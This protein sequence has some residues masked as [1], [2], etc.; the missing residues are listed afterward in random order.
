[1][2]AVVSFFV[3]ISL[4]AGFLEGKVLGNSNV[5]EK[6]AVEMCANIATEALN[7]IRT[8]ASLGIERRFINSY[9]EALMES[10]RYLVIIS[11]L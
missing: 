9:T 11:I 6:E 7:N 8:V 2:G 1:M 3:P 5:V 4:F 10:H